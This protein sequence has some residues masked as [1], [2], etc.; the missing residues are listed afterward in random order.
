M[1]GT[2]KG[3]GRRKP[4]SGYRKIVVNLDGHNVVVSHG[5]SRRLLKKFWKIGNGPKLDL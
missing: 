3:G 4:P 5:T 1:S 2:K